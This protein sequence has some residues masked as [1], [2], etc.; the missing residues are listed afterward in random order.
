MFAR[1]LSF[2]R[3]TLPASLQMERIEL[4]SDTQLKSLIMSL[5]QA[6]NALSYQRK[7]TLCFTTTPHSHHFFLAARTL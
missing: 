6:F 2:D 4:Q 3:N 7:N 5:H 1:P